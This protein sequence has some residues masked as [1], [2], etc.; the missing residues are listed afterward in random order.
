[1][2]WQGVPFGWLSAAHTAQ[3]TD[4]ALA[5]SLLESILADDANRLSELVVVQESPNILFRL[6]QYRLPVM[7]S[8]HPDLLSLAA[9]FGAENCFRAL[10]S[11]DCPVDLATVS[12]AA[13]GGGSLAIFH[14]LETLGFSFENGTPYLQGMVG[15]AVAM[16]HLHLVQYFWT[17]GVN[18]TSF[19]FGIEH[20]LYVASLL[21]HL[22][23][24]KFLVDD[25][26][27]AVAPSP[28]SLAATGASSRGYAQRDF[29]SMMRLTHGVSFL[30]DS[31]RPASN[32]KSRGLGIPEDIGDLRGLPVI[33]VPLHGA[34]RGGHAEVVSY[35]LGKDPRLGFLDDQGFTPLDVAISRGFVECVRLLANV[36][37]GVEESIQRYA[38]VE[39]AARGEVG[40]LSIFSVLGWNL[41]ESDC[42]GTTPMIA[43]IVN[44]HFSSVR[45]LVEHGVDIGSCDHRL[46]FH[47][48][49]QSNDFDI[50]VYLFRE[51]GVQL[52]V[53]GIGG[54]ILG[55]ALDVGHDKI[56]DFM[57]DRGVS[58]SG[59]PLGSLVNQRRWQLLSHVISLGGDLNATRAGLPPPIVLI[60]RNEGLNALK[61]LQSVGGLLC[62]DQIE[63][64]PECI[65]SAIANTDDELV[66]LFL[67]YEPK[68]SHARRLIQGVFEAF[69]GLNGLL[70]PSKSVR[71]SRTVRALLEHGARGLHDPLQS[72]EPG[73]DG[74]MGGRSLTPVDW[75]IKGGSIELLQLF[76]EFG[77]DWTTVTCDW[78]PKAPL[79]QPVFAFLT[80]R[81]AYILTES[82]LEGQ[83]TSHTTQ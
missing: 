64:H 44:S 70:D 11:L 5:E 40:M 15:P 63:S 20:P 42:S 26:G 41:N 33:T 24:I 47:E 52:E 59:L 35:L 80:E 34:C 56:I 37:G 62:L 46:L 8:H 69:N 18:L 66:D 51:S 81:G 72:P 1:M 45:F 19:E 74:A 39:A 12:R 25:V 50:F 49:I 31:S 17:K 22:D 6:E 23:I 14:E 53:D 21:N 16:G 73:P 67:S 2:M 48:A 30:E 75:A 78:K 61:A 77:F 65:E 79:Q 57:V 71:I 28:E 54:F 10:H 82:E 83:P 36:G 60:V 9:F 7:I 58:L 68:I 55:E 38:I 27:I 3:V 13:A 29:M 4:R 76:D 32:P 43:S